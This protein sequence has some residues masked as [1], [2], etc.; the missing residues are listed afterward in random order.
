RPVAE[1]TVPGRGFGGPSKG[2]QVYNRAR[3]G[4]WEFL[5]QWQGSRHMTGIT[6]S[7]LVHLLIVAA[8]FTNNPFFAVGKPRIKAG[9]ALIV[10]L[11]SEPAPAAAGSPAPPPVAPPR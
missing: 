11:K 4:L 1:T 9:D 7:V 6:L 5:R 10:D 2:P 8:L 3:M